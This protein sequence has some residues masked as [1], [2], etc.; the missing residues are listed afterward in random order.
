MKLHRVFLFVQDAE[1]REHLDNH[2]QVFTWEL[3]VSGKVVD[4]VQG[5][6]GD[7]SLLILEEDRYLM[8][9][10]DGGEFTIHN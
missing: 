6:G 8:K 3:P 7:V 1:Y 4:V 10:V 5:N 9:E 2:T